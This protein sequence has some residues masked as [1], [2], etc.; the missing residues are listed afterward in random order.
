[1]KGFDPCHFTELTQS[2]SNYL[3]SKRGY[4]QSIAV[5]KTSTLESVVLKMAF[6][7]VHR[8]WITD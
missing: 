2:C 6:N 5:R 8:V 4:Y 7:H 3:I 1:M